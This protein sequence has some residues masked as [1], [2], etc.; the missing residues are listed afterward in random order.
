MAKAIGPG[1]GTI[2]LPQLFWSITTT[3]S[4]S[5][6][7]MLSP[8]NSDR[9]FPARRGLVGVKFCNYPGDSK[10]GLLAKA[11]RKQL[12]RNVGVALGIDVELNRKRFKSSTEETCTQENSKPSD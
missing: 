4:S 2:V 7:T 3:D 12:D 1:T 9:T 10:T 5:H 6:T 11:A 8:L